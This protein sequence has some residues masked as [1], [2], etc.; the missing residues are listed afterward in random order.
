M[1][2]APMP[3]HERVVGEVT[4]EHACAILANATRAAL[5]QLGGADPDHRLAT[6]AAFL[7]HL[8][9]VEDERHEKMRAILTTVMDAVTP[10]PR[11]QQSKEN[12]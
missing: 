9:Q 3:D 10:H 7:Y 4:V 8:C 11:A 6:L 1:K 12:V 2:N 5:H